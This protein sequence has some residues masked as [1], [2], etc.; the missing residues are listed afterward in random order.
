MVDLI[1]K[2]NKKKRPKMKDILKMKCVID[3]ANKYSINIDLVENG[4]IE[5]EKNEINNNINNINKQHDIKNGLKNNSYNVSITNNNKDSIY[6]NSGKKEKFEKSPTHYSNKVKKF[7]NEYEQKEI[8]NNR[9]KIDNILKNNQLKKIN[10]AK[11]KS[12]LN[13]QFNIQLNHK[14]K[15]NNNIKTEEEIQINNNNNQPY[16]YIKKL[17]DIKIKENKLKI[18]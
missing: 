6:K 5:E 15:V 8:K 1:L 4:I 9:I 10:N 12:S 13:K 3:R 11:N 2:K 17:K 18:K 14:N 7:K 16:Q